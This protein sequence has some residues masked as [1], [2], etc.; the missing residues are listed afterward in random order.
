MADE[1]SG[2][3]TET[4]AKVR[5]KRTARRTARKKVDATKKRSAK[6]AA[7]SAA[8]AE[9]V[10]ESPDE[11]ISRLKEHELLRAGPG[12]EAPK[13]EG[14]AELRA[15]LAVWGPLLIIGFFVFL[16][17]GEDSTPELKKDSDSTATSRYPGAPTGTIGQF[18][19]PPGVSTSTRPNQQPA[20]VGLPGARY[21]SPDTPQ[22][23]DRKPQPR[24]LE[25]TSPGPLYPPAYS[26]APAPWGAMPPGADYWAAPSP[27]WGT[28]GLQA[29][30]MPP[31]PGTSLG[32]G[33]F[34]P[35]QVMPVP[36]GYGAYPPVPVP[37]TPW[38]N[39]TWPSSG[40]PPAS[41]SWGR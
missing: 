2:A 8:E 25:Q 26:P 9:A 13:N 7:T 21:W 6:K 11:Q 16:V 38:E 24:P 22:L 40:Y 19:A 4:G 18:P 31:P 29:N 33:G 5:K 10:A 30:R 17:V 37:G 12:S 35:P 15:G 32:M 41:P 39:G 20:D 27:A 1:D 14:G 23:V 34:S 28:E 36:Q 3:A